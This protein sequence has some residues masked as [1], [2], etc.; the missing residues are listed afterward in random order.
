M[1]AKSKTRMVWMFP[2]ILI[3]SWLTVKGLAASAQTPA[4][5]TALAST[6]GEIG[7]PSLRGLIARFAVAARA[8]TGATR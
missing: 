2:A 5:A 3:A 6:D 7:D 8:Q 1:S 4:A